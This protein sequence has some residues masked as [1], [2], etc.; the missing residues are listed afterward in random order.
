MLYSCSNCYAYCLYTRIET[1][2]CA[3]HTHI[4]SCLKQMWL[5]RQQRTTAPCWFQNETN[6]YESCPGVKLLHDHW[7]GS[8]DWIPIWLGLTWSICA[9]VL[10]L[11]LGSGVEGA[12]ELSHW[13][14]V[15]VIITLCFDIS[16]FL[17]GAKCCAGIPVSVCLCSRLSPS[18]PG[19]C[20]HS[21]ER[22]RVIKV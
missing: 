16:T 8:F 22:Q 18:C 7:S 9:T 13:E 2:T 17:M 3:T 6:A 14:A 4:Y 1:H 20:Q 15:R 12:A 19:L 21:C 5:L 11:G 10:G